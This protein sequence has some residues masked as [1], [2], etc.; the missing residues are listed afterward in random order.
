MF[1]GF[2]CCL[3]LIFVDNAEHGISSVY[4]LDA[5]DVDGFSV[6]AGLNALFCAL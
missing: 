2:Y 5:V 4:G 1:D 3:V 6:I